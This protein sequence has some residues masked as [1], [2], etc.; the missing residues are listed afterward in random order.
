MQAATLRAEVA[1][2]SVDF[3]DAVFGSDGYLAQRFAGYRVRDGQVALAQAVDSAIKNRDGKR[4]LIAE[5]PTGTGKSLAYCV[6]AIYNTV[7]KTSDSGEPMRA[8]IVTGN[9]ALQEQL[10]NKDLPLLQ[11]ILPV[12]FNFAL[13]K[14]MTNYL[15]LDQDD[16]TRG[17]TQLNIKLPIYKDE[18]VQEFDDIFAWSSATQTGDVSELPFV[19]SSHVWQKFSVSSEDCLRS[20]CDW[21]QE[22]FPMKAQAHARQSQIIVTNYHMLFAHLKVRM[23]TG[24]IV[25]ILPSFDYLIADEAHKAADIAREFFGSQ[26]SF[27]GLKKLLRKLEHDDKRGRKKRFQ[28]EA[29]LNAAATG[30]DPEALVAL[31]HEATLFFGDLTRHMKSK[32]Y[33]IRLKKKD[34]V[35]SSHFITELALTRKNVSKLSTSL[36]N[37][38]SDQPTSELERAAAARKK[39][40]DICYSKLGE[41]I[42]VVKRGMNLGQDPDPDP[43]VLKEVDPFD[44]SEEVAAAVADATDDKPK[45]VFYLE[46][47][48]QD[49]AVLRE[50]MIDVAGILRNELFDS[51]QSVIITSATLSTGGKFDY[52]KKE[53]GAP[54]GDTSEMIAETPFNYREQSLLVVP[55]S[56]TICLPTDREQ[57]EIDVPRAVHEAV[58]LA[59]GRTLCLFTSYKNLKNT[60]KFL[61]Q[62]KLPFKLLIQN[63]KPRTQLIEEFKSNESSVLLGTESFWA[64]VDVPGAS[65]SCVIIDKI[66]FPTPED[67]ILDAIQAVDD[68][69][70]FTFSIPRAMIMLS[71]GVGR[72]IRA[73]TDRGVVVILDRRLVEKGYGSG[74]LKSLPPMSRTRK[75]SAIA[76]FLEES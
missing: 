25:G 13:L 40:L 76:E 51:T 45:S 63:D 10:A 58:T 60:A 14:G 4:H 56:E 67:P 73:V 39:E 50:K 26:L 21:A 33:K 57:F 53:L 17:E 27:S 29:A 34:P 65:L 32:D 20:K 43:V 74:F 18:D 37:S 12:K 75:M 48:F 66:P 35:E 6:P 22:C 49:R 19:P 54:R 72:L 44:L 42:S 41:A 38:D 23:M 9:I 47:D 28:G 61:Q 46:P 11:Q 70:F 16:T 30:I 5:G 71:Q 24:G 8:L 7:G 31:E 1:D 2:Q 52:I 62:K 3:I 36:N 55:G 68:R 64:G 69:A 15:C 59:K